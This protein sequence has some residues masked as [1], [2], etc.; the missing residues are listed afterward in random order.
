MYLE[1]AAVLVTHKGHETIELSTA[2]DKSIQDCKE[3][4]K[5]AIARGAK[6]MICEVCA[7][8]KSLE[9]NQLYQGVE[10][11][12]PKDSM[13][14]LMRW[15]KECDKIA[16]FT[17]DSFECKTKEEIEKRMAELTGQG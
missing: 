11:T 7:K 14:Y 4:M 1:G 2:F 6:V 15:F 3:L 16:F 13:K 8:G 5:V 10:I 17:G 12:S 9:Q